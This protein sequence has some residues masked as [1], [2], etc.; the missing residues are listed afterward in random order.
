MKGIR[1]NETSEDKL[2]A[3]ET[4]VK[5]EDKKLLELVRE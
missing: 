5:Y 3:I 4:G 1:N 2:S